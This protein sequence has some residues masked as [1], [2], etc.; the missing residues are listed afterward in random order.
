MDIRDFARYGKKDLRMFN[1]WWEEASAEEE[2]KDRS[3]RNSVWARLLERQEGRRSMANR[4][5]ALCLRTTQQ[6]E[7]MDVNRGTGS[8][9]NRTFLWVGIFL[10][11]WIRK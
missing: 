2:R 6:R 8:M 4:K 7:G 11:L 1:C 3:K 10:I 5:A 9:I